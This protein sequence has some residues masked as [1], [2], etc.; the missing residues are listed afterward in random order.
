MDVKSKIKELCGYS[1]R[2]ITTDRAQKI[3]IE[4]VQK[5]C[6]AELR[7]FLKERP[8]SLSTHCE[9]IVAAANRTKNVK[10][11]EELF[12]ANAVSSAALCSIS[13]DFL[14][15]I[16]KRQNIPLTCFL[17]R[18]LATSLDVA[19]SDLVKEALR[20]I[21][22]FYH[23]DKFTESQTK[24]II[25]AFFKLLGKNN[26][27]NTTTNIRRNVINVMFRQG[28][29][30]SVLDVNTPFDPLGNR[31]LHFWIHDENLAL[32]YLKK[33]A[34]PNLPNVDQETALHYAAEKASL[35][36]LKHIVGMGI[37]D[38]SPIDCQGYTPL[39]RSLQSYRVDIAI[40]LLK[41]KKQQNAF[42]P[43]CSEAEFKRLI[44]LLVDYLSRTDIP[45]DER[46]FYISLLRWGIALKLIDPNLPIDP[47]GNRLIHWAI[48]KY[49][50]LDFL[51]NN[52]ADPNVENSN[53]TRPIH[54]AAE[55]VNIPALKR[56]LR[57]KVLIDVKDQNGQ[58][59]L[60]I[61]IQKKSVDAILLFSAQVGLLN[62]D[63][64]LQAVRLLASLNH[65]HSEEVTRC[66]LTLWRQINVLDLLPEEQKKLLPNLYGIVFSEFG[67]RFLERES[68]FDA[69]L[70]SDGL[71]PIHLAVIGGNVM[72]VKFLGD[73]GVD[74]TA[75]LGPIKRTVL[76]LALGSTPNV[77]IYLLSNFPQ[78]TTLRASDITAFQCVLLMYDKSLI[79]L[80]V[81]HCNPDELLRDIHVEMEKVAEPSR[82]SF[83]QPIEQPDGTVREQLIVVLP[84]PLEE[85]ARQ[86]RYVFL[87]EQLILLL[88]KSATFQEN[89]HQICRGFNGFESEQKISGSFIAELAKHH[90][91]MLY[92]KR[93]PYEEIFGLEKRKLLISILQTKEFQS[94]LMELG[95]PYRDATSVHLEEAL[96]LKQAFLTIDS[97]C[98][99]FKIIPQGSTPQDETSPFHQ[100]A[101]RIGLAT[102]KITSKA[103]AT[104]RTFAHDYDEMDGMVLIGRI[105]AEIKD[106][107]IVTTF[108][109]RAQQMGLL[110][111]RD[112]RAIGIDDNISDLY[113]QLQGKQGDRETVELQLN[114]E[115]NR[116]TAELIKWRKAGF[117]KNFSPPTD[118]FFAELP[119]WEVEYNNAL[120]KIAFSKESSLIHLLKL[121]KVEALSQ[122]EPFELQSL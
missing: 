58:S 69:P 40:A 95:E 18:S 63:L 35:R 74:M 100:I 105:F 2:L 12:A 13:T 8:P 34:D 93:V 7:Y 110:E 84:H 19:D 51:L 85:F 55:T 70:T 48:Q 92:L 99:K 31:C 3:E 66:L 25:P 119:H 16:L 106:G 108:C 111:G 44:P 20:A 38:V 81:E 83:M 56:L 43:F 64:A 78:L 102:Q 5:N 15:E 107:K 88:K 29:E 50:V 91:W 120:L 36:V 30:L 90:S 49:D 1:V 46:P 121:K 32:F 28:L 86:E 80:F 72:N 27:H 23:E 45:I 77:L 14:S 21:V 61:S 41:A 42:F 114:V 62:H 96:Q 57:A 22:T 82:I 75:R 73:K 60:M 113:A 101:I 122:L 87:R 115:K 94:C 118:L 54:L 112:F 59:P 53:K 33:G 67:C 26:Y 9:P 98:R 116:K 10:L 17:L 76:H 24:E 104:K 109:Q 89:F 79:S 68:S 52:Q 4:F 103:A 6:H 117:L 39:D 65:P 71:F 11:L 47:Q 37:Q 97:M